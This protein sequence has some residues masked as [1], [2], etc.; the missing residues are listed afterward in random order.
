MADKTGGIQ[1]MRN[2]QK[3]RDN[4]KKHV[5]ESLDTRN[6]AGYFDLT[7]F[8]A[9]ANIRHEAKSSTGQKTKEMK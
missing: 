5:E 2:R 3:Q 8:K 6:D 1:I 4:R 9:V 7:A